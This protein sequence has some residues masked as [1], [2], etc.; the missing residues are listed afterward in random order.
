MDQSRFQFPEKYALR[1][2]DKNGLLASFS[3]IDRE[4]GITFNDM[5]LIEGKNGVFVAS[6]ARE[7]EPKGGGKKYINYIAPLYDFDSKTTDEN[8]QAYFDA[9]TQAALGLYTQVK[10]SGEQSDSVRSEKKENARTG[11]GPVSRGNSGPPKAKSYLP[12]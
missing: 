3:I 2:I 8:G 6:A 12:F 7:Y 10:E 9:M 1:V 5:R 11:R 4:L